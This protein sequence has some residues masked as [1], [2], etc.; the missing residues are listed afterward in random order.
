MIGVPEEMTTE[1]E[2]EAWMMGR[3]AART[4]NHG[5]PSVDL[6][7]LH[8]QNQLHLTAVLEKNIYVHIGA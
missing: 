6:V 2:G 8:P 3:V 4:P 5:S 7:R 1:L